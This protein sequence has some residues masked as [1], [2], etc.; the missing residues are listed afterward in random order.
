MGIKYKII[1]CFLIF[2][3]IIGC[4]RFPFFIENSVYA[5][6]TRSFDNITTY[7]RELVSGS[8]VY[9]NAHDSEHASQILDTDTL[10][11]GQDKQNGFYYIH[12]LY[13]YFDTSSIGNQTIMS[14]QLRIKVFN[15]EWAQTAFNITIQNGQPDY[16]HIPCLD[17]DFNCA[18]YSGDGGSISIR[19]MV[20]NN[21][22]YITLNSLGASW[23]NK[24]G[25]TK[26]CLRSS[27]DINSDPP[28]G[29]EQIGIYRS[30][31]TLY[32]ELGSLSYS[33]IA[34]S[35]TAPGETTTFSCRWT[36]YSGNLSGYIFGTNNSGT[37]QNDT[38]TSFGS[39]LTTAW[40]NV[41]KVL[42]STI[43]LIVGY[44]WWCNDTN[45]N[46]EGTGVHYLRIGD[47]NYPRIWIVDDDGPADF[48]TIQEAVNAASSGDT[49]LVRNGTYHE[50]VVI[51]KSLSL[52][53]EQRD[54]TVINGDV[55]IQTNNV[56]ISG[57]TANS[58]FLLSCANATVV[59]NVA[60]EIYLRF[61]SNNVLCNNVVANNSGTNAWGLKIEYSNNNI[62]CNNTI[63]N[64]WGGIGFFGSENNLFY[65][66]VIINYAYDVR[67][68]TPYAP[69]TWD[70]GYPSGGNYYGS[71][72]GVDEKSGP[73]QNETGSDGIGDT[74]YYIPG[75]AGID[76]NN[77]DRYPLMEPTGPIAFHNVGII[78]VLP[79]T[80]VAYIGQVVGIT[81]IAK[82]KG[83]FTENLTV[84]CTVQYVSWNE[85]LKQ[86]IGDR[87]VENVPPNTT[88]TVT[89]DWYPSR[90]G[91]YYIEAEAGIV[92]YEMCISD[93]K[94]TYSYVSVYNE[95]EKPI[96]TITL[97]ADT[98]TP[99]KMVEALGYIWFS[100][101]CQ[102]YIVRVDPDKIFIN[103]TEATKVFGK[104]APDHD[105]NTGSSIL[106]IWIPGLVYANGFLWTVASYSGP[107][108]GTGCLVKFDPET[109]NA[110]YFF[111]PSK[112]RLDPKMPPHGYGAFTNVIFDGND[113][114][115]ITSRSYRKLLKFSVSEEK[116]LTDE[117]LDMD[118]GVYDAMLM[119][120]TVYF[121]GDGIPGI[122][123]IN[124]KNGTK[125]LYTAPT[126]QNSV[127][128]TKDKNQEIWFT[129]N[130]NHKVHHLLR[131]GTIIEYD[132]GWTG[133][134]PYEPDAPYGL[135]FDDVGNLWIAGYGAKV[136]L[137]MNI[138]NP[139]IITDYP[140]PNQPFYMIKDSHGNIW[141]W[142]LGSA[143][144]NF[145]AAFHD[146][147]ITNITFS[148]QNPAP[149]ETISIYVTIENHGNITE[150]FDV[151]V[152]Y[153]LL[154]DPLI[155]TQTITLEPGESVTLNFTWTPTASGRYEIKAYTST[156]PDDIN[157]SDNTKITYLYVSATYTAAFSTEEN[158]WAD[159]DVRGGRFYFM[160]SPV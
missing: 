69:N 61:S 41:T 1:P 44:A 79:S 145:I 119:N 50:T 156:I 125:G 147:T 33:D 54:T 107:D 138:A 116:W 13:V 123:Y 39:G 97:P 11:V 91:I 127:F 46:W 37:W 64:N 32:L 9:S 45:G 53:G 98:P 26:L 5:R 150:T 4:F 152:N 28:S 31:I 153:T 21:Y 30:Q 85:T 124:I 47:A 68:D 14:A 63:V 114:L 155:G 146:V 122:G 143:Q 84:N 158:D 27:R 130:L 157:P 144:I 77:K 132:L 101:S 139:S 87:L 140:V 109:F 17:T 71:Y 51:D 121:T 43:G 111:E 75:I 106:S 56:S 129:S 60:H 49:I 12:R 16:P 24:T 40:A 151:S 72:S 86:T 108:S 83:L 7:S 90:K 128:M 100:T 142:G 3:I 110:T 126:A 131:N 73:Y 93:N 133:L 81:I 117:Y 92:P 95:G 99:F 136:I 80:K 36:A 137:S 82:N 25:Y 29:F 42:N 67:Q 55:S 70:N 62:I 113:T 112:I 94:M 154:V 78:S 105:P 6:T 118:Y 48:H 89:F 115:Y 134:P 135:V 23:I 74:P 22:Y 160:T 38:W 18:Y 19:G 8:N 66:N 102:Q 58:F 34:S 20:N 148:K 35:T 65:G 2:T 159:M 104:I 120:D 52:I 149:N 76:E 88:V 15:V 59:D 103:A 96:Q 10:V 141:C 57:F